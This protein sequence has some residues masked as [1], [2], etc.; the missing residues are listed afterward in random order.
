LAEALKL[1]G[2]KESKPAQR[3]VRAKKGLPWVYCRRPI[4]DSK[5]TSKR[6]DRHTVR[7]AKV[8]KED[9]PVLQQFIA[10]RVNTL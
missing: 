5:W 2:G 1:Y 9:E 4:L 3:G 10:E 8:R 6:L 7:S